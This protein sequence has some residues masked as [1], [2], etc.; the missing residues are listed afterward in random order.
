MLQ[1]IVTLETIKRYNDRKEINFPSRTVVTAEARSWAE[2]NGLTIKIGG[3]LIGPTPEYYREES[4]D[5]RIVISVI[6]ED[7]V[8]IIAKVSGVLAKH[9]VNI[10]DITQTSLEGLF[11]MIMLVDAGKATI[12]FEKLKEALIKAGE[13]IG[14]RIDAQHEKVFRFMHRI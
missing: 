3:K 11:T 13:E 12:S 2:R 7:R 1:T 9:N 4:K 8:G 5:N 10:L 14:V 6:G